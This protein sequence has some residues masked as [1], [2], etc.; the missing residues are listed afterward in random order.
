MI[1]V[2]IDV[3]R[4]YKQGGIVVIP[5]DDHGFGKH[6]D[7]MTEIVSEWMSGMIKKERKTTL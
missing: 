1:Y 5:G 6:L 2:G 4:Q 3:A 7:Q